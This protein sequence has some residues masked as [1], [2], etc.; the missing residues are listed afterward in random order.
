MVETLS[1]ISSV[2]TLILFIFYFIGRIITIASVKRI[3]RD[4]IIIGTH[5]Y[6]KYD[7]VDEVVVGENANARYGLLLS[8]EGIRDLKV[9]DVTCD[10]DNLP[11]KRG[12]L[13]LEKPFINVDHAVAFRVEPGE[14]FPTLIIEY[15]TFDYR[16]VRIEWRDN[17]KT[18]VFSEFIQPKHTL[19]SFCYYLFR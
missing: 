10:E 9:Y 14:L 17:L 8:K 3:W 11:I 1:L 12:A 15:L 19:R 7:I 18:G 4:K 5:N 16:K 2:A 6:E 13:L